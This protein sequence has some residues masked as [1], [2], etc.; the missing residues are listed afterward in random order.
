MLELMGCG[1]SLITGRIQLPGMSPLFA[2]ACSNAMQY[3]LISSSP[4]TPPLCNC[5]AF[6]GFTS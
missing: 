1:R 2:V 3:T 6:E 5:D 4:K